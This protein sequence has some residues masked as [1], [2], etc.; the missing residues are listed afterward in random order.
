MAR[1][2]AVVAASHIALHSTPVVPLATCPKMISLCCSG[3]VSSSASIPLPLSSASIP[4]PLPPVKDGALLRRTSASPSQKGFQSIH[5]DLRCT[6]R[7]RDGAFRRW[8]GN[9]RKAFL[10]GDCCRVARGFCRVKIKKG[11]RR[12]HAVPCLSCN[13]CVVNRAPQPIAPKVRVGSN[14]RCAPKP[15]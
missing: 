2:E 9:R 4:L 12:K 1:M 10:R 6:R 11:G 7:H 13:C 14:E 3:S 15:L 5:P 8:R